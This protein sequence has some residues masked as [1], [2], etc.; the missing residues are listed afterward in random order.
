MRLYWYWPF[1]RREE[2]DLVPA[3]AATGNE[4][5]VDVLAGAFAPAAA[6]GPGWQIRPAVAQVPACRHSTVGWVASRGSTY[7]RRVHDR[8]R[9]LAQFGPE[10]THV[11]FQNYLTDW[12]DLPRLAGRGPLVSTVHDVVPHVARLPPPLQAA[13]LRSLYARCGHIVVHHETVASQLLRHFPDIDPARVTVIEPQV[14]R[15]PMTTTTRRRTGPVSLLAFGTLRRNKGLD[16]LLEAMRTVPKLDATL[17]V[18]GRGDAKLERR[19]GEAVHRDSRIC[20]EIGW[21][22]PGRK[23]QLYRDADV[24]VLPYTSFSSQSGVLHDAYAAGLP[25]VVADVGA[26][27]ATVRRDGSGWVVPPADSGA[28]AETLCHVVADEAQRRSRG[29]SAA[30]VAAERSPEQVAR[31]LHSLYVKVLS[32][33]APC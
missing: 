5:L 22:S 10:L 32:G 23:A 6:S 20:A 4:M 7:A 17:T 26:L 1:A 9:A 2:V 16:D 24:V 15:L 19:L 12:W 27:G 30:R 33:R 25:L 21:V 11:L 18:A 13:A 28:L 8:R 31:Q 29:T 14:P 3:L